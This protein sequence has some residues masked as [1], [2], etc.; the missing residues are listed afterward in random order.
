MCP[1]N[2]NTNFLI[3]LYYIFRTRTPITNFR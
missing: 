3:R 2:L 1:V